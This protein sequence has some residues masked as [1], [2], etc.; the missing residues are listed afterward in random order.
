M[1]CVVVGLGQFGR[2]AAIELS[3]AGHDVIAIDLEME[4]VEEIKEKVSL[5]L[6]GD[7]RSMPLLK[8]HG[9]P[10]AD[11]LIAAIRDDFEA[12]ALVVA[13]AIEL[14]IPKVIARASS[15]VHEKVLRAIGAQTVLRPES[16]AANR[17]VQ[18]LIIP[19]IR[20]YFE[21]SDGFSVV[22]VKVPEALDGKT[23]R[24]LKI[25]Q[26]FKVNLIGRRRHLKDEASGKE[27]IIFDVATPN[28]EPLQTGEE[29]VLI[30][31]DLDIANL[32]VALGFERE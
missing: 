4:D 20:E 26:Q 31:T 6:C 18:Q 8:S 21:L 24:E 28:S 32:M 29:L 13:N 15:E 14:G 7:A 5:A 10:D 17:L 2:P 9:I 30:G 1:R 16:E 25:R 11:I 23:L 12:Q 27:R 3:R 22:E 19:G